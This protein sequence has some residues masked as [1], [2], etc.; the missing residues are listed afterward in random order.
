MWR[1]YPTSK[2]RLYPTHLGGGYILHIY[3]AVIFQT[4][5]ICTVV[6][7]SLRDGLYYRYINIAVLRLDR[8]YCYSGP[9]TGRLNYCRLANN[10]IAI[11]ITEVR[12]PEPQL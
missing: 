11:D 8:Q 1:L 3:M 10:Y 2:W 7:A 5:F 4:F 6:E 12:K 9:Q